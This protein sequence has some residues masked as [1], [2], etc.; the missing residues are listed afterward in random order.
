MFPQCYRARAADLD[1]RTLEQRKLYPVP[2][3]GF[4]KFT[5]SRTSVV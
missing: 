5:H 4:M 2:V 3:A 1:S